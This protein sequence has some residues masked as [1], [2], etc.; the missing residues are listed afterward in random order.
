MGLQMVVDF[1]EVGC[2]PHK[3]HT[4]NLQKRRKERG[5]MAT[6]IGENI[7]VRVVFEKFADDFPGEHHTIG[8]G[9]ART[10]PA[11]SG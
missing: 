10:T 7:A 8:H 3:V 1:P 9:R 4:V 2:L 5:V 6:K 11:L